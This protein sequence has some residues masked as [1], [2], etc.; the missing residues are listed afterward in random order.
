MV[1]ET[2]S[3]Q[4]YRFSFPGPRLEAS[5]VERCIAAMRA[6]A[7]ESRVIVLSG[8]LP[9]GV[10]SSFYGRLITE[11]ASENRAV[12][13]DTSGEALKEALG[14][15]V[16][17]IKPNLGEFEDLVGKSLPD[18]RAIADAARRL[19]D[20]SS[21]EHV[22]VSLGAGGV[23]VSWGD[24]FERIASPTVPIRS[25]VGAGDSAVAGMAYGLAHK[26]NVYEAAQLGVAAGAAT[27]MSPGT[28]LCRSSDVERLYRDMTG[29]VLS[30]RG[31]SG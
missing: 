15:P 21:V 6:L 7:P 30:E 31:R 13:L 16:F 26:M 5:E 1:M 25:R 18:D 12:V 23:A 29:R 28:H 2:I 19:I 20:E 14:S 10:P 3:N 24:R 11:L 4:Q 22:V 9:P 8:S 27:V 17:L